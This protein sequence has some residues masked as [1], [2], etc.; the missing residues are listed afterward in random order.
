MR[1]YRRGQLNRPA[2][3]TAIAPIT[4]A[5]ETSGAEISEEVLEENDGIPSGVEAVGRRYSRCFGEGFV[6]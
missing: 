1:R 6:C 4:G 3:G 5:T 2:R